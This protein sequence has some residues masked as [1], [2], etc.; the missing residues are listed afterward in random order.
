M[1][2]SDAA[3]LAATIK[4]DPAAVE[5]LLPSLA[6]WRR[7][8]KQHSTVDSWRY[9]ISWRR[10]PEPVGVL[11]GTWRVV[12]DDGL[13]AALER[14]GARITDDADNLLVVAPSDVA[15]TVSLLREQGGARLWLV[16]RGAVAVGAA[17]P[18]GDPE[19]AAVW[20]LGRVAGLESPQSWGGLVDLPRDADERVL[21]RLCAVLAAP[22]DEDQ[23]AVRGDGV[24]VRRLV[25]APA[26]G[27]GTWR[28]RGTVLI[29]GGTGALATHVAR[30]VA[31][32]GA[33][34]IVLAS[35]SGPSAPGAR[36]LWEELAGT[37]VTVAACDV[38][39]RAALAAL[40]AEHPPNSVF[41]TA[42]V[43][44]LTRIGETTDAEVA[45]VLNAKVL[46]ARHL[47]ELLGELDAFVLFSSNAGVWGSG[48]QGVYAAANAH[49]D[50]LAE[51]R[52]ARGLT[53]TSVAWGAWGGTGIAAEDAAADHLAKHGLRPMDPE[54]AISALS[55]A[56]E[57]DETFVAVADV[58]WERFLPIFTSARRRPLL[59][60][61]PQ[62]RK[63]RAAAPA[64]ESELRER[65]AGLPERDQHA[66]L[67][68]LVREQAAAVLGH[69]GTEAIVADRAF[70]DLGFDSLT[71]VRLRNGLGAATGLRLPTTLVFDHPNPDALAGYLRVELLGGA[72]PVAADARSTVDEPIAIVAMSCRYPGGAESPEQ[73]WR[74][75]ADGVDTV[76]PA[77][78]DRG[79][80]I[81]DVF[82]PDPDHPGTTYVRE[83]AFVEDIGRF[84]AA[85][86]G[87][88][89]REAIAM[90]PQ[91]RLLLEAS[92][93]VFERAGI[94]PT[95][96]R[97]AQAGVFVG[98]MAQG[99][100]AGTRQ[101]AEG[102]EGYFLT[103]G[104]TSVIS[105]R[106]AYT[107]GLEGPAVT[108]DTACSSSL[109]ALHL[110]CQALRQGECTV[111]LA[112]GV[113]VVVTPTAFV[114]FSRQRGLAPD[115]RCKPFAAAADGTAWGEG[116]GVLLLERLSDA[117]RNGHP[118]LAVVRGSA[119]NSDGASN[120]L[121]APNGLSQQRVIRAALA[122]A[123]L[124][125]SDV[126]V[127]EAHGT[128]TALGDP[129]EA[130]AVIA[131]YGQDR[132]RPL[133]LGSVKSNIGH[134]AA[135]SGVAGVIKMV[136]SMRTGVLPKTLHVD[137]PTPHVDWSA[138]D[139]ALLTENVEWSGDRRRAGVSS[140]GVSGT[141]A[142]V[143]LEQPPTRPSMPVRPDNDS[144][145]WVLSAEGD[146]GAQALKLH[147]FASRR[148]D[149]RALDIGYSL[150][151]SRAYLRKRAVVL[152]NRDDLLTG[153]QALA[154]GRAASNVIEAETAE[155]KLAFLFSGQGS[156]RAGMG[157]SL[158]EAYP[159]FADAFDAVCAEF[160]LP[161][162]QAVFD[163]DGLDQTQFTQTGLFALEVALFWLL[164]S[165]GLRPDHLL[166]HSVGELAAAHV[167]GVLSLSDACRLVEAR[168]RLMQALPTGGAMVS[169]EASVDEVREHLGG[170]SIAAV[171]GP[172]STVISGDAD[173]VL[174]I[175]KRWKHKR[176]RTSHAFHSAHMDGML[177]DF[178]AVA[179]DCTFNAPR[180]PIVQNT[181]GD[182]TTAE[183]WVRHVRDAVLFHDGMTRLYDNGVRACVEIGP[184][185]VLSALGQTCVEDMV[186]IPVLRKDRDEAESLTR[187]VAHTHALGFDVDLAPLFPG[188]HRVDL[189][190]YAFQ[191]RHYWL[192]S[193]SRTQG[194]LGAALPLAE[195]DA[196]VF[197]TTLSLGT[198]P[199]LGDHVVLG[200]VLVPG[201]AFVEFA[202]RAGDEVG[203][204]LV[205]ELV[206]NAPLALPPRG[207]VGVQVS[208][209]A[210]D[211][212]G[213]RSFS[214]HSRVGEG[215]WTRHASGV[216]REGAPSGTELRPWPPVDASSVDVSRLYDQLAGQGYGYGPVFQG[217]TAAWR[218]GDEV[219]A[220][221]ALPEGADASGFALHPA[222]L[223]SAL[224]VLGFSALAEDQRTR[225]PFSWRGIALFAEG[226]SALRV[227]VAVVGP[228][229]VSV[230]VA[231]TTGAPVAVIE[232]LV[233]R[234]VSQVATRLP[235]ELLTVDLVP[236]PEGD[237][238]TV[239]FEVVE[240]DD[241]ASALAAIRSW[242]ADK[243]LV[244]ATSGSGLPA[245][246]VRGLV[247]SAQSEQPDR[248]VLLEGPGSAAAAAVA[249]GEPHVVVRDGSL[250][251]PRLTRPDAG[252][253]V[254]GPEWRL[255][256]AEP[257]T[258]DGL[259]LVTAPREP[260]GDGQV[261]IGV[262]A[263]GVN[264]RDVLITLGMYPGDGVLGSEVA[265]VVLE[266]AQGT[267]FAPG[268]RVFGLVPAGIGPVAVADA[269]MIAT[270]PEDWSFARAASVPVV[271][272]TAY[273]ALVGLGGLKRG[274]SVLVH[275]AAGGVGMAAVQ[276]AR[277]IGAEVFGTASPAK[278]DATGLDA[279][280]V[281]S[282]RALGFATRFPQVDVV[283]N[284]LTG[285]FTDA[286]LGLLKP[287]G[288]FVE[289]G[290]A[291][292]R[293]GTLAFDLVDLDPTRIGEML[294][295]ILALFA[296]GA[297]TP[298]PTRAW[299][300]RQAKDAFRF[301]SQ[302]KHVG[303]LV[304][305]VP[306]PLDP[307]GTVVVTGGTG[308]LGLLA[309]RHLAREHGVRNLLL[310]SRTGG[311]V[312]DA[313]VVACD[314]AD[315]DALAAVLSGRKVTA[316]VHAA[317]VVDDGLVEDMTPER[318]DAVWRPK[319][320]AAVNLHEL[321]G[322]VSAFVL[323]SS[324]S[325]ILGGPGQSNYAAANAALDELAR[326]RRAEGL[327]ATSM[328]WG[329]WSVGMAAG[330][331]DAD[332]ERM[333][334]L[335]ML[336]FEPSDI[337]LLDAA[338]TTAEPVLLP[339]R[340]DRTRIGTSAPPLLRG[341]TRA[342]RRRAATT[343]VPLRQRIADLPGAERDAALLDFVRTEVAAVLGLAAPEEIGARR[344]FSDL[345]F[346]SLTAVE[347]RNRVNAATGL[348]MPAT[349]VYDHPTAE[350]L[351]RHLRAELVGHDGPDVLSALDALAA[352]LAAEDADGVT[353]A[354]VAMRLQS[355]L[356][357]W[358]S[359]SA[360]TGDL[361][362]ASDDELFD[363]IHQEMGRR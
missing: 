241:P 294:A 9:R 16:T 105:G 335:G 186:F 109:V 240:C 49:L 25:P 213:S 22:G 14:A 71:S 73:L 171:N 308:A 225:L 363:L 312:P 146:L 64:G 275:S 347:L 248:F 179:Q 174:E 163:G 204:G 10:V 127:V 123:G 341:L 311:A 11:G 353:H 41:H 212:S 39:D 348:R 326:L 86:F 306:A 120:G 227:R 155:G 357:K 67:V 282:S 133:W 19:Q 219:F 24:F 6:D 296:S 142:H 280:H 256:V 239:D 309:A 276:I 266:A 63:L 358:N 106:V 198:H 90:D 287:G 182:I 297:L 147:E 188:A 307:E 126:D 36:E 298:L 134:T 7:R 252:L 52:R 76:G 15:D 237:Q 200:E 289:M 269:R 270:I 313:E 47:D 128:G 265:G 195:Q 60:E 4:A 42:G 316:V 305:T 180:I 314:V 360:D 337:A 274:Q 84:D 157:R 231:D 29:T 178:R 46:G 243:L 342:P 344:A 70:R 77:P 221:V 96:L 189:P 28:P 50:A 172:L 223:D 293:E 119:V 359:R 267:G 214:V 44:Q 187:A 112:G 211:E 118:V 91:Q 220:E 250:F 158:Y 183:Y 199:W 136:E 315:R 263:A 322:D 21:D 232:S 193:E 156:Q 117:E 216:L 234:A 222:L 8:G 3:E 317:G 97:G 202:L 161:V 34:H 284:A 258:V 332:R 205:D 85:L 253:T 238:S 124:G 295:E 164:H 69:Q 27:G 321:V 83:G 18:P 345:G 351:V 56:L 160:D 261:R 323:F 81:E 304:L 30:W 26:G 288:R 303:K 327:A 346:D 101:A 115:G 328:A 217:L 135:A 181:L 236:L 143:I 66:A 352:R 116:V 325:G 38:T 121:S 98:A 13:V 103:G 35:R 104:A 139:V 74:L 162:R 168:G 336:P 310:L 102:A 177:D 203:C 226:A 48:G 51:Q 58:D 242:D 249:S 361:A 75:L 340:L 151:V 65:L 111:A 362:G 279:D 230:T 53:A 130:Q 23:I 251:A 299:D 148:A 278:W 319:V 185:G 94:D 350:A 354:Q 140:F 262:R 330:L 110:A 169:V 159:V 301:L 260:L 153:L 228:D 107:F 190:T 175:A 33:D 343:A 245:A 40:V 57:L 170:A 235:E 197:S 100:G 210:L 43:G 271:F 356:S 215:E 224:H 89:P 32:N 290:K 131:T 300:V 286:S 61:L 191:R 152:G 122:N 318:L 277:H 5:E 334:G 333:R 176:L 72:E 218:R 331:A 184:D 209:G 92:W 208:V 113:T 268:D 132:E 59:D 20:G 87:I 99:Y 129:I 254:P 137:E 166:G 78:A 207:E 54:L 154:E 82:H 114:E 302:A 338:F 144:T 257:G 88:A 2:R 206:L 349:L 93:E 194:L 17:D 80:N 233:L 324:A 244:L 173:E 339:I 149:L 150:A 247:A 138:G 141:N 201:T 285:E 196:L 31:A 255:A 37:R 165:W 145:A 291:D 246:G 229:E 45:A 55:R 167:S 320:Q 281:A 1:D 95:G 192:E 12:G 292:V 62:A 125:P 273:H 272:L 108:V 283:L 259:A 329:P 79:W 68:T 264:F 355:I